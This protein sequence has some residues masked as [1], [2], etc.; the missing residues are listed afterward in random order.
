MA[1]I[2]NSFL[3]NTDSLVKLVNECKEKDLEILPPDVNL[4]EWDFAVVDDR[5]RFGL[6]A[7]KNVGAAAVE[8]IIDARV[9]GG[10]FASLYE[11]CE[12]VDLQRVN[13][14]Q[15]GHGRAR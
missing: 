11:F 13:R 15:S 6:G 12:R 4:S 2:L 3:G 5:I 7:V 9:N 1:A 8:S 10:P 14:A